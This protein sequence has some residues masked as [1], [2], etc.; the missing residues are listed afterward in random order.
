MNNTRQLPIFL[1]IASGQAG[2]VVNGGVLGLV[3]SVIVAVA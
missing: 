3:I 1:E 2:R